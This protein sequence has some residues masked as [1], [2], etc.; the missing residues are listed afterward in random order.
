MGMGHNPVTGEEIEDDIPEIMECARCGDKFEPEYDVHPE[1]ALCDDCVAELE[2]EDAEED[3]G[4]RR[5]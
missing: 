1:D 3:D 4:D 5:D 2:A